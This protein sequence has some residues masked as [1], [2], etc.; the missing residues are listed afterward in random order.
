MAKSLEDLKQQLQVLKQKN[1]DLLFENEDLLKKVGKQEKEI[2]F[3][4]E[5]NNELG[6]ENNKLCEQMLN[7]KA[8]YNEALEVIRM[9]LADLNKVGFFHGANTKDRACKT[10]KDYWKKKKLNQLRL[11][12]KQALEVK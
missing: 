5:Q 10:L 12:D 3:L 7:Y 1:T 4:T 6:E 9:A 2:K 11:Y 8:E